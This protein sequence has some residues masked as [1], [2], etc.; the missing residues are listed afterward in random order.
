MEIC[1]LECQAVY[2]GPLVQVVNTLGQIFSPTTSCLYFAISMAPFI[3]AKVL[4]IGI[5]FWGSPFFVPL[6]TEIV[7]SL[8]LLGL[9]HLQLELSL[10]HGTLFTTQTTRNFILSPRRV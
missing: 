10:A 1:W 8:G 5:A 9:P 3:W 2:I 6:M 7:G 4:S